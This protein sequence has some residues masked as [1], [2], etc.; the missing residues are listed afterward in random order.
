MLYKGLGIGAAASSKGH[1]QERRAVPSHVLYRLSF[2]GPGTDTG[3]A[4]CLRMAP[5]LEACRPLAM[6]SPSLSPLPN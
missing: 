6:H 5:A 2:D 1:G 3:K 4:I